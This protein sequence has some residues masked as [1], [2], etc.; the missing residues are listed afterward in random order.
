MASLYP[1]IYLLTLEL[2]QS[3]AISSY[4]LPGTI[5]S[6]A[7]FATRIFTTV[8]AGILSGSPVAGLRPIRAFLLTRTSFPISGKVKEPVFV[9][10]EGASSMGVA[11]TVD[12]V[13]RGNSDSFPEPEQRYE[14]LL[15]L[16]ES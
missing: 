7:A 5:A 12:A 11:R 16:G 9:I 6:L 14:D 15:E 10:T 3:K 8:L 4:F 2:K 1:A 13:L